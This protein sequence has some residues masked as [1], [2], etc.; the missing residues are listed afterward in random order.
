MRTKLCIT[1]LSL[2]SYVTAVAQVPEPKAEPKPATSEL[3]WL[4]PAAERE[5]RRVKE[6]ADLQADLAS[7]WT[8]LVVAVK[9]HGSCTGPEPA[10]GFQITRQGD[11]ITAAPWVEYDKLSKASSREHTGEPQQI[12]KAE[13]ESLLSLTHSA[14]EA[15]TRSFTP[16]E[17]VGQPPE[18]PSELKAWV[19]RWVAA[20]GSIGSDEYWMDVR[21]ISAKGTT[22]HRNEWRSDASGSMQG[23]FTTFVQMTQK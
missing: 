5:K 10:M 4:D 17:I 3:K 12:T 16:K 22:H 9:C 19:K 18:N 13:L 15:A 8:T 14:Y 6:V 20:G 23:L 11:V 1:T 21:V 2:T 7:T